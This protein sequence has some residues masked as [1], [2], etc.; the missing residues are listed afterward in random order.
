MRQRKQQEK[1]FISLRPSLSTPAARMMAPLHHI[2]CEECDACQE[3]MLD[4]PHAP[5]CNHARALVR[6]LQQTAHIPT[7][8]AYNGLQRVNWANWSD[9]RG[10]H[11]TEKGK[12][13]VSRALTAVAVRPRFVK[14]DQQLELP[15]VQRGVDY[16]VRRP[17]LAL[18]GN[19][20]LLV[21]PGHTFT[22]GV[23]DREYS[24]TSCEL[25]TAD[26][27][28]IDFSHHSELFA[29]QLSKA[30]LAAA[31]PRIAEWLGCAVEELPP[32]H[33]RKTFV[34]HEGSITA[35]HVGCTPG[36]ERLL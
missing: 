22:C 6:V 25:R 14:L 23:G 21:Q 32:I 19:R 34:W 26:G 17:V 30:K 5:E 20:V 35:E 1:G 24:P 9:T 31:A 28:R 33:R 2:R 13:A 7:A 16:G 15:R 18:K 12:G 36:K 3:Y 29:G 10:W 11:L 4:P 8:H 27:V